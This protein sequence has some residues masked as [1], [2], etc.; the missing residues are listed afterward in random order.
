MRAASMNH[1]L[2]TGNGQRVLIN[3]AA[4]AK[5]SKYRASCIW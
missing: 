5:D 3:D 2:S 4:S 1:S